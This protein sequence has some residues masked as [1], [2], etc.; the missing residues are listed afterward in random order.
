MLALDLQPFLLASADADIVAMCAAVA[1]R[2]YYS[3]SPEFAGSARTPKP[4]I[5]I[6]GPLASDTIRFCD[7]PSNNGQSFIRF[8]VFA[9]TDTEALGILLLI[10]KALSKLQMLSF[11]NTYVQ[12]FVR[13]DLAVKSHDR[14]KQ[15]DTPTDGSEDP[16]PDGHVDFE[17]WSHHRAS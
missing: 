11:G 7:G 2:I 14:E 1:D 5:V 13:G 12:C 17:V 10:D 8:R 15:R 9:K 6:E 3:H 4:H 16:L